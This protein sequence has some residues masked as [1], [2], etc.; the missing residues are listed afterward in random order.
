MYA[1]ALRHSARAACHG[2]CVSLHRRLPRRPGA[3]TSRPRIPVK[4]ARLQ[5]NSCAAPVST[6]RFRQN[7]G[8]I[9]ITPARVSSRYAVLAISTPAILN[10]C[11]QTAGSET[12]PHESSCQKSVFFRIIVS[13]K[14]NSQAIFGF[15]LTRFNAIS[16][17]NT[18]E[19]MG[20]VELPHKCTCAPSQA[21]LCGALFVREWSCKQGQV[22][23]SGSTLRSDRN[24]LHNIL[25]AKP[26]NKLVY[27]LFYYGYYNIIICL[28]LNLAALTR[29]ISCS[30]CRD[31]NQNCPE[32]DH[33]YSL[34]WRPFAISE[35]IFSNSHR[36]CCK[37]R[38]PAEKTADLR[39]IKP[40]SGMILHFN[41]YPGV[42]PGCQ[43]LQGGL[44]WAHSTACK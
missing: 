10:S 24:N 31:N 26:I 8:P 42:I 20:V 34:N 25:D 40:R 16:I 13:F 19:N 17:V 6:G 4:T 41:L 3:T 23:R 28:T 14:A 32:S 22:F 27:Y 30:I 2:R 18:S 9:P 35:F 1:G 21:D 29:D 5:A 7:I 11:N 36:R 15:L 37:R 39:F 38:H 44:S 43:Y 12:S 33:F